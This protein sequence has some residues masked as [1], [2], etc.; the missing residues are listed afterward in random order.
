MPG[1]YPIRHLVYVPDGKDEYN[2]D[3]DTWEDGVFRMIYG[4]NDPETSEDPTAGPNRTII[5][6]KL[7][8]PPGQKYNP[9]DRVELADEPGFQYEVEG[10]SSD[11]HN[12]YGWNPGGTV[13]VRRVDG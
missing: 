8:I 7:L 2:N 5:T 6:R 9:R 13:I 3:I 12:P 10:T 4:A 1:T 11:G